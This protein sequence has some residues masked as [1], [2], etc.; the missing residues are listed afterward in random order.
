MKGKNVLS[1][2]SFFQIVPVGLPSQ[3]FVPN[4]L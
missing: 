3:L 1:S 4:D 2:K